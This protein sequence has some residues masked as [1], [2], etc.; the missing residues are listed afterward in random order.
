MINTIYV[1]KISACVLFSKRRFELVGCRN[2]DC[3]YIEK[4]AL[5]DSRSWNAI[6]PIELI[7]AFRL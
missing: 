3:N 7:N 6:N 4:S 5:S 2:A 1:M